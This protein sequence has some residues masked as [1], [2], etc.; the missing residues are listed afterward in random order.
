LLFAGGVCCCA[1][2]AFVEGEGM[3][4]G[5]LLAEGVPAADVS[6]AADF[7]V[8]LFFAS[9]V[10]PPDVDPDAVVEEGFSAAAPSSAFVFLEWPFLVVV[11]GALASA[12]AAVPLASGESA[13]LDFLERLFFVLVSAAVASADFP[14]AAELSLASDLFERFFFV[15]DLPLSPGALSAASADFLALL[16]LVAGALLSAV[17]EESLAS[18][19][20]LFFDRLFFVA[21]ESS[22]PAEL[23]ALAAELFFLDFDFVLL[24]A[25][26]DASERLAVSSAFAFF[27]LFFFVVVEL[28]L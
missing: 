23:S 5:V 16:F 20:L 18:A 14:E 21:V 9:A 22:V 13:V 8:R 4:A 15:V 12:L 6:V 17:G 19:L 26:A 27:L 7:L 10:S 11:A 1:L 24:P 3:L 2:V 25:S 28:S